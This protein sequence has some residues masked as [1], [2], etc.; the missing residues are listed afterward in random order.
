[1][2]KVTFIM[3][4]LILSIAYVN[5]KETNTCSLEL[6]ASGNNPNSGSCKQAEIKELK[7]VEKVQI[8]SNR[9]QIKNNKEIFKEARGTGTII[10]SATSL[11]TKA[12]IKAIMDEHKLK[13]DSTK[14]LFESW[15]TTK[16]Q[17]L[18]QIDALKVETYAPIKDLVWDSEEAL[19]ILDMKKDMLDKNMELRKENVQVKQIFNL[20]RQ[21]LML[22][23]KE[24]HN[25]KIWKKLDNA[26]D[27]KLIKLIDKINIA[28]TK[29]EANKKLNKI[30]KD[31]IGV[32][33]DALKEIVNEKMTKQAEE[34]NTITY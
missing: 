4:T 34:L 22:K 28:I 1:M 12:K 25:K 27:K 29:N 19:K 13:I 17:L 33:L 31:K 11:E 10:K 5:A 8:K 2:R 21:S 18:K 6:N 32:Q 26:G 20:Q 9:V 3:V 15:S 16:E 23:Y 7:K 30:N 14:A 24:Q